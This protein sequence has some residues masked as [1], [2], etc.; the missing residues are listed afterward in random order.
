MVVLENLTSDR[1][2]DKLSK[3][4]KPASYH[5]AGT[6]LERAGEEEWIQKFSAQRPIRLHLS[7]LRP[8]WV[9]GGA[10]G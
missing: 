7:G 1:D 8:W 10:R 4:C 5:R 9:S 3:P 6:A 2:G